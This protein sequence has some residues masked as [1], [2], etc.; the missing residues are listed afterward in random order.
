MCV[1]YVDNKYERL[2]FKVRAAKKRYGRDH[3][4]PQVKFN[5]SPP[6]IFLQKQN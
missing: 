1:E 2:W 3:I 5:F 4:S 6:F